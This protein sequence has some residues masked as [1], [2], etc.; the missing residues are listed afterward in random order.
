MFKIK[1]IDPV[2]FKEKTRK[3]TLIITALFIVIGFTCARVA[4][5]NF[6]EYFDGQ[7]ILNFIGGFVGLAITLA[8]IN[9]YFK[10]ADWMQDTFYSWEL[11]R[12][13]MLIYNQLSRVEQAVE[14]D[15]I[16]AIKILRFYQLANEQMCIL[17]GNDHELRELQAKMPELEAKMKSLGMDAKQ[18]E[19]DPQSIEDYRK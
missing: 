19:F 11:K 7:I 9:L 1:K 16:Q 13:L 10:N 5:I 2:Q 4:V 8:I 15:D 12:N 14:Q 17:E 18:I 3:S 6:S